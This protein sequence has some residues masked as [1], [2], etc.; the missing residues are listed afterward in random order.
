MHF[1]VISG[2]SGSGKSSALQLLEDIDFTCVDN[3][4][5]S[6]LPALMAQVSQAPNA[7]SRRFAVGIDARNM[8]GD[9]DRF[10]EI[11]STI[12]TA[13]T[14]ATV[15]Y[16]D[17]SDSVL[18]KRFSETRRKHPLTNKSLGLNEAIKREGNI[19]EPIAKLADITID[20]S[21]LTIHELRRTVKTAVASEHSDSMAL[22]LESF[23]FKYGAPINADFIFDVRSLPNP[24]WRANLRDHTGLEQPVIE[25][26]SQQAQVESMFE[27]ISTFLEKWLPSFQDNN[28]SY[29]TVAIGCTGGRHR[30]VYLTEKLAQFFKT[31]LNNV[32][33][34]HR[35]LI[36]AHET[37]ASHL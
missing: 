24:H 12:Q 35:Q 21:T 25:F 5:V 6:L 34:R 2:R 16:L 8:G 3:L 20:T 37:G 31:R 36:Q 17:A 11:L 26:L 1:I 15:I 28:R 7:E 13:G 30:S 19:L 27:D 4:P 33:A 29:L 23:G 32:Q 22:M 9:L 14:T 18:I 10:P